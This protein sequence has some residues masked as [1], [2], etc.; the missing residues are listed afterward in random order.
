MKKIYFHIGY[1]RSGSTYIQQNYFSSQK[2]I[3]ILSLENLIMEVK[4]IFS[5][6]LYTKL[7]HLIK[8]NSQKI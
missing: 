3:L 5:I 2:K 1:P 8:K 4:I 6:K 7:L